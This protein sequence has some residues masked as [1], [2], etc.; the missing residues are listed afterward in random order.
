MSLYHCFRLLDEK[1]HSIEHSAQCRSLEG[2]I[3]TMT[4]FSTQLMSAGTHKTVTD[5][6]D[7]IDAWCVQVEPRFDLIAKFRANPLC[8]LKDDSELEDL[9]RNILL[10]L[11]VPLLSNIL[12]FVASEILMGI[13][14]DSKANDAAKHFFRLCACEKNSWANVSLIFEASAAVMAPTVASNF[15]QQLLGLWYDRLMKQKT[16]DRFRFM[17]SKCFGCICN[18]QSQRQRDLETLT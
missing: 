6:R 10:G 16:A 14:S 9:D 5:L 12:L 13:D 3:K 8:H 18:G 2:A 7:S 11:G 15:Q 17:V 4:S 1:E